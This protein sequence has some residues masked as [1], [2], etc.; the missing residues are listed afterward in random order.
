MYLKYLAKVSLTSKGIS[1]V[2]YSLMCVLP[3]IR[4]RIGD[5]SPGLN[6]DR[7]RS[8]K[9][10]HCNCG[11]SVLFNWQIWLYLVQSLYTWYNHTI[12]DTI[13]VYLVQSHNLPIHGKSHYT[14]YNLSIPGT[15]SL[16][17]IQSLYAWYNLS[18]SCTISLYLV[19]YIYTWCN[20]PITGTMS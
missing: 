13:S 6:P 19:Q 8:R 4:I 7:S 2:N 14:W 11:K 3:G 5:K 20:L 18:V 17:L 9:R 10:S 15:T 12:P 1:W 16:N